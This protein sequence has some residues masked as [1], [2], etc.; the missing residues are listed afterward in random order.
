MR[1][2]RSI[3]FLTV[4]TVLSF[5]QLNSSPQSGAVFCV[6][7][8]FAAEIPAFPVLRLETGKHTARI[9]SI[10]V[11]ASGRWLVSASDDKTVRLWDMVDAGGGQGKSAAILQPVRVIRPPIGAGDLGKFYSVAI[12]PD[13]NLIVAGGYTQYNDSFEGSSIYL[14]SRHDGRLLE[15]FDGAVKGESG[16]IATSGFRTITHMTFSPDGRYLAVSQ[17][18]EGVRLLAINNSLNI[19]SAGGVNQKRLKLIALDFDYSDAVYGASFSR[20]SSRLAVASIDGYI[21]LYDAA[22]P[23]KPGKKSWNN[24]NLLAMVKAS[25]GNKPFSVKFSPDGSKIAVGYDDVAKIDIRSSLDLSLLHT[26]DVSKTTAANLSIVSW[27]RDGKTLYAGG[28]NA[29]ARGSSVRRWSNGGQGAATDLKVGSRGAI[30]ELLSLADDSLVFSSGAA[31]I[32][33]IDRNGAQRALLSPDIAD[34]RAAEGSL[35]TSV[36]GDKIQIAF[37]QGSDSIVSYSVSDR[38]L[39]A[40]SSNDKLYQPL[41]AVAEGPVINIREDNARPTLHGMPLILHDNES[42]L[43]LAIAPDKQSFAIGTSWALCRFDLVGEEL[44]RIPVPGVPITVNITPD[45][46]KL[47]ATLG[48]GTI[49]W[50]QYSD[51]KEL[52]ALFPHQDMKRWVLWTESGFFDHAPGGEELVGFHLNRGQDRE[53]DFIPV[54]KLYNTFY[55][56]DL[57]SA[58]FAGKDLKDEIAAIDVSKILTASTLP[59]KVR[60]KTLSAT[61]E[62]TEMEFQAELCDSGGGIGDI[63]LFLNNM[64]IAV[65]SGG[66]GLQ[67]LARKR[68]ESCFSFN[69]MLTLDNGDNVISVMAYNKM[70]TI[71]SERPSVTI[72]HSSRFTGK[73]N[74]HIL[75]IAVDKYRDGDLQLK[76]SNAD[77]NGVA[78]LLARQGDGLFEAISR[79]SLSDAEVNKDKLEAMFV[80]IGKKARREDMFIMFVAGHGITHS[81]TGSFYFL[82]VNF[83]YSQDEDIPKHGISMDDFKRYLAQIQAAKSLLLLDTCNSGS[84][85]EAIASRGVTEKTAI[86]KLARAVGRHTLVAS[87]KSQVALEGYEG[88]GAFS[89]ILLDGIKGKAANGKGMITVNS[90]V[91]FVEEALPDLTYKKWGYEQIPQKSLVG[92]DFQFG[93]RK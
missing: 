77:A 17:G 71:E 93:M 1:R 82:P 54:S 61:V 59:P 36:N 74:L 43:S 28:G 39:S 31:A 86:N 7:S 60:I 81:K 18:G 5:C 50:Y 87:S 2:C 16:K 35:L 14:F 26:P 51:G 52:M 23:V 10:D 68:D 45:S 70:N 56:P 90:L 92:E 25:D 21:R 78:E 22:N 42:A 37:H 47:I 48:D 38:R 75:T 73:P 80:S 30:T 64:P 57:I 20:D 69:R 9:N 53:A 13:G 58:A 32:G 49:R 66:R 62:K 24:L 89:Y 63:T 46:S 65:D 84:F 34:F 40:G 88:H 85:A 83:R 72:K 27:S 6:N 3:V 91:T 29:N 8:V 19:G 4:I 41:I 76:Y 67:L 44:W 15:R 79:Y 11:D 33:I 55:R 12:S